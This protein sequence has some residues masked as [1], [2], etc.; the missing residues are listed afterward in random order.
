MELVELGLN[1]IRLLQNSGVI[2]FEPTSGGGISI[3]SNPIGRVMSTHFLSLATIDIFHRVSSL[4][5][6]FLR[7]SETF[8]MFAVQR[9]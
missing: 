9:E 1:G 8:V 5:F 3:S 6:I 4:H 2:S 7:F